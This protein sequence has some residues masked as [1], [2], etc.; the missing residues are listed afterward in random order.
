VVAG[1]VGLGFSLATAAIVGLIAVALRLL[2]L[3]VSPWL[4]VALSVL[5]AAVLFSPLINLVGTKVVGKSGVLCLRFLDTLVI[6]ALLAVTWVL[7][8]VALMILSGGFG[9]GTA[10]WTSRTA[11]MVGAYGLSYVVGVVVIF[12][13]AGLGARET[14]LTLLLTPALGLTAAAALAIVSRIPITIT[15][16]SLALVFGVL[17]RRGKSND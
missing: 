5:I 10:S 13:P 2:P 1:L 12:A 15:D 9:E 8:G 4:A 11:A 17:G 3:A 7:D 16:F 14:A 6:L